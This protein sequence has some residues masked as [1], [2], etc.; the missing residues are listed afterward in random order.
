MIKHT[1]EELFDA[2]RKTYLLGF[3]DVKPYENAK[4]K[5]QRLEFQ[6]KT[7]TLKTLYQ[8][9]LTCNKS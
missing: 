5:I 9:S 1:R 7:I 3:P 2:L 6:L 4:F 8:K